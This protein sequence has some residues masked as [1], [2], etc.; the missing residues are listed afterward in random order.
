[1]KVNIAKWPKRVVAAILAVLLAITFLPF[2]NFNLVTAKAAAGDVP[3]HS[4][5]RT[6]NNDPDGDGYGDGTYKLELSVTGEADT[7]QVKAKANILVIYDTSSSMTRYRASGNSGPYRADSAEKAIYDF[8]HAL[9]TLSNAEVEMALV[10][11]DHSARTIQ[12]WT[13]TE[14]D[15]TGKLSATGNTNSRKLTYNSGTNYQAGVNEGARL[16]QQLDNRTPE[17]SDPTVVIFITDGLPSQMNGDGANTFYNEPGQHE[18]V[19]ARARAAMG[20]ARTMETRDNTTFYGIYAYGDGRDYLDDVVYYAQTGNHRNPE[21]TDIVTTGITDYYFNATNTDALEA[22]IQKIFD[23]I[24]ETLGI[25]EVSITDGTTSNVQIESSSGEES[26]E[27][28]DVDQNSFEYWLSIPVSENSFTRIDPVTGETKKY[29]LTNNNDGT[30]TVTRTGMESITVTGTVS[31][32]QFKFKWDR[33]TEL[34]NGKEPPAATFDTT[35]GKVIWNLS[36]EKVGTLLHGVT[37]SVTFDVFPSQY[38]YDLIAE[39]DNATD[40]EAAYNALDA[41][42]REYLHYDPTTGA[43]SLDTNKSGED[44]PTITWTDTRT[45]DGPQTR[46]YENPDS[47]PTQAS[48]INLKKTWV[49][50][51]GAE[52]DLPTINLELVRLGESDAKTETITLTKEGNMHVGTHYIAIGLLTVDKD[53]GTLHLYD[54]GHDYQLKESGSLSYHWELTADIMHPMLVNGEVVMMKEVTDG[55]EPEGMGDGVYKAVGE[56]EYYGFGGNVYLATG[57]A[58]EA[59]SAVNT[60]RANLNL[61]KA[62]NGEDAPED[63]E[64]TFNVT[65]DNLED[66]VW[67][68]LAKDAAG[69]ELV[70]DDGYATGTGL[71]KEIRTVDSSDSRVSEFS[72]NEETGMVTYRWEDS[73]SLTTYK[74]QS[75][76]GTVYTCFTGFY[77]IANGSTFTV[78][79]RNGWNM[80]STN[81]LTGTTFTIVED[82]SK[83]PEHFAFADAE[84][85][86]V[87][88]DTKQ[89]IDVP[90]EDWDVVVDENTVTGTVTIGNATVTS[91]FTNDYAFEDVKITK[92]WADNDD[93]DGIRPTAEEFK[94]KLVL[95]AGTT[96][97]TNTYAENLTVTDNKDNTYTA[98]WTGLPRYGEGEAVISYTVEETAITGYTTSGSPA[99]DKGTITNTHTPQFTEATVKKVWDDANN[100]DGKRPTELKVTLSN[101]TEVTLNARNQWTAKVEN[102][103][104]Y[105]GGQEIEYSWTETNV[106]EGYTI[107]GNT[108]DGTVTTITNKHVPEET[109]ATVTKAWVDDDNRDNL[110]PT[111]LNVSLNENVTVDGETTTTIVRT[112][113]LKASENWTATVTGLPKYK[114]GNLITYTWTEE[115]VPTGY[116][117]SY[118]EG[119]DSAANG[120]TITNTHQP[121][122]TE[123]TV[124]KVWNDADNQDGKRPGTLVVSLNKTVGEGDAAITTKVQDVTLSESED[125]ENSWTATVADLPKYEAGK[126]I[127]YTWA[128]GTMPEG[129]EQTSATV[130]GTVTTITNSYEPEE[131]TATVKKVWDD[132]DD[133][134]GKR[135]GTL[136]VTLN[137][138]VGEGDDAETT[139][140][141]TV[142]LSASEEESSNWTATVNELPMYEDGALIKYTWSEE[143][144][145]GY[146]MTSNVTEATLTTITNKH[147]PE[148]TKVVVKK[149]WDDSDNKYGS[150]PTSLDV[151]LKQQ[152]GDGEPT[153]VRTV[154]LS[155]SEDEE[156]NWTATVANLPKYSNKQI[157]TYTWT[158]KTVPTGYELLTP[159]VTTAEDGTTT[160]T[161]TNKLKFGDLII[162]K[163]LSTFQHF[164]GQDRFVTIVFHVQASLNGRTVF[165]KYMP[166]Q[167]E[168]ASVS[169]IEILKQIPVGATVTITEEYS[170]AGYSDAEATDPENPP[171]PKSATIADPDKEGA[172]TAKVTF[173]NTYTDQRDGYGIVN[174]YS[175][176]GTGWSVEQKDPTKKSS[177]D[178]SAEPED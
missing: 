3:D 2:S 168:G 9:F 178:S 112:V 97:V 166:V 46:T 29:N 42:I 140:V 157:V 167:M 48:E 108:T 160:T 147:I 114:N 6:A 138:T 60:R 148:T 141:Q 39:L 70:F 164:D 30:Y 17:D 161:L 11:Y 151:T 162:E 13:T 24:V 18:E 163:D 135:P 111:E 65:I 28:L 104:K 61:I 4:K 94:S 44:A 101:G 22:A 54:K 27:L 123:A 59:I 96:D 142:T 88:E 57:G 7:T 10:T 154:T 134:D 115:Q 73:E 23:N 83:M 150:R 79:L 34:S 50:K 35:T 105:S 103:P 56:K 47:V 173:E 63:A 110:R 149:I 86:A 117:V 19:L 26:V 175:N 169:K 133:R 128:E 21:G 120:G 51:Y 92:V 45:D 64:F 143:N 74:V 127:T 116:S 102:L 174:Q 80:R 72:Y 68:S 124:V 53:A 77:H 144:I 121:E 52:Q 66:E 75:V 82:R 98:T 113:M 118:G 107:T 125:E 58:S 12:G 15:I 129:Y 76:S 67:F 155:A 85:T 91:T 146:T 100:Q 130:K 171:Q 43:F 71:E 119:Q 176:D 36:Y 139:E 31:L 84:V 177:D 137:K 95:M 40:K 99:S 62:V 20:P 81:V 78:K 93:Q 33:A 38:T 156:S 172:V 152:I 25:G 106:P 8:A 158:E 159:E 49:G 69:N 55:T 126:L 1:M 165:D 153:E 37:Y 5:T 122:T 136:V 87:D 16:I 32:G 170:G 131:T 89:P 41:G 145:D 14:S 132:A 90:E 109:T